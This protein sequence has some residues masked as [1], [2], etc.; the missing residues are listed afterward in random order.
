M[1]PSI[2][3][4]LSGFPARRKGNA[5]TPA[6]RVTSN[7]LQACGICER[8]R[9]ELNPHDLELEAARSQETVFHLRSDRPPS[10][11]IELGQNPTLWELLC[12]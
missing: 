8:G 11:K 10:G 1:P 6:K 2:A 4:I 5:P 7:L 12:S 9:R 3:A